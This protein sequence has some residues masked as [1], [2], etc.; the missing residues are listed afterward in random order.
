[1]NKANILFDSVSYV[2]KHTTYIIFPP[3]KEHGK[4]K[5]VYYIQSGAYC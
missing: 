3:E 2:Y 1:M 5:I 4:T